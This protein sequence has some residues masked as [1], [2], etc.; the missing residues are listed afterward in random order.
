MFL[1]RTEAN[2]AQGLM[3]VAEAGLDGYAGMAF[4]FDDDVTGTFTMA[5]TLMP[6]TV[7]FLDAT[8]HVVSTALMAPCPY[9]TVQ[10]KCPTYPASGPYRSAI[11][12]P[13][14]QAPTLGL[15]SGIKGPDTDA[16]VQVGMGGACKA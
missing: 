3:H 12:V 11:E 15:A 16:G 14:D 7:V 4:A 1:A 13:A 2:R 10:A 8:G 6:L 5:N 9:G